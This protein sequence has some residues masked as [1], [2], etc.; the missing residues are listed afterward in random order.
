MANATQLWLPLGLAALLAGCGGSNTVAPAVSSGSVPAR[1]DLAQFL[2]VDAAHRSVSLTLVA[3][4]GDANNGFNFD[5]YGRG[6][7]IV[8][9]PVG[10]RTT[11]YCRI[12]GSLRNSCA[13]VQGALSATLAFPGA[14]T[15]DPV[16]GLGA[17]RSA[18]FSFTPDRA[19]SFRLVSLVPGHAAA[20]MWDVLE[21]TRGGRPSISARPGA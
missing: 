10:W 15:P 18:T 11:V 9:V 19:G 1:P 14:G 5:G 12:A 20:R 13:V 16:T 21:V 8:S 6:E 4:D 3:G 17:G 7:L 2:R